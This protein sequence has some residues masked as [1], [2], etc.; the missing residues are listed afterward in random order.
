MWYLV[1]RLGIEPV[2]LHWE[3]RVSAIVSPENPGVTISNQEKSKYWETIQG[4]LESWYFIYSHNQNRLGT[5]PEENSSRCL[6]M[7]PGPAFSVGR[8][9]REF[10]KLLSPVLSDFIFALFLKTRD[11]VAQEIR[12]HIPP[13]LFQ[14]TINC[15]FFAKASWEKTTILK[16]CLNNMWFLHPFRSALSAR[17]FLRR[18]KY[19]MSVQSKT[20][21]TVEH[22]QSKAEC[23]FL[24]FWLL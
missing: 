11:L 10:R 21:E 2:P 15:Q 8:G 19:L 9:G 5:L 4:K 22:L 1:P 17:I 24:F 14:R 16:N 18:W 13:G 3:Y 7:D 20:R 23:A 6:E 12:M